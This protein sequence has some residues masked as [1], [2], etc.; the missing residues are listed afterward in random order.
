MLTEQIMNNFYDFFTPVNITYIKYNDKEQFPLDFLSYN[1][2]VVHY[3]FVDVYKYIR[4]VFI[5]LLSGK[6][7]EN[8]A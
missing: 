4:S 7:T 2:T 8:M 1:N 5:L 6:C 3:N